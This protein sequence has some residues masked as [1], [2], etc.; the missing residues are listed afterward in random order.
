MSSSKSSDDSLHEEYDMVKLIS[1]GAFGKVYEM[2]VKATGERRAVKY[3]NDSCRQIRKEVILLYYLNEGDVHSFVVKFHGL[4]KD[5]EKH[6]LV[7]DRMECNLHKWVRDLHP[8]GLN[9]SAFRVLAARMLGAFEYLGEKG[10]LHGDVKPNNFL[11]A[12]VEDPGSLRVCDF[13]LSEKV[14][15]MNDPMVS[16]CTAIQHC[17]CV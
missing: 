14:P 6:Y 11:L 9:L 17:A 16:Q 7:F 3:V 10:V 1:Q 2:K 5:Q 13:G 4:W 15:S 8:R 12:S